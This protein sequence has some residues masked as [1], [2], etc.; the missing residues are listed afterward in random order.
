ME[1]VQRKAELGAEL[2]RGDSADGGRGWVAD[3][4]ARRD[5][6]K[7]KW[8]GMKEMMMVCFEC[9]LVQ[10]PRAAVESVQRA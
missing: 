5:K 1:G 9:V 10:A 6:R 2:T 7:L 3:A 8:R 4:D